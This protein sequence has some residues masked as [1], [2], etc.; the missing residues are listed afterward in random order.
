MC[1]LQ[2]LI[3]NWLIYVIFCMPY[4][5]YK[6]KNPGMFVPGLQVSLIKSLSA[7]VN[8]GDFHRSPLICCAETWLFVIYPIRYLSP[9]TWKKIYQVVRLFGR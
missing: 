1:V 6:I 4:H 9:F 5:A 7:D 8:A 3:F 2:L